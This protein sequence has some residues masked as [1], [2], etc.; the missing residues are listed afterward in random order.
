MFSLDPFPFY[1]SPFFFLPFCLCF[2]NSRHS[3]ARSK[4]APEAT[5][6]SEEGRYCKDG[7]CGEHSPIRAL[8]RRTPT[9]CSE[10]ATVS[11]RIVCLVF[12]SIGGDGFM[13]TFQRCLDVTFY[14]CPPG[15]RVFWVSW[16]VVVCVSAEW[17]S[18]LYWSVVLC[19]RPRVLC[20]LREGICFFIRYN[21]LLWSLF[22][23]TKL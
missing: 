3:G 21:L 19:P 4:P 5:G 18:V 16:D 1:A 12:K 13:N 9:V 2:S 6:G 14:L 8:G 17:G 10:W 15:L 20:G 7:L 22:D 11:L 23:N